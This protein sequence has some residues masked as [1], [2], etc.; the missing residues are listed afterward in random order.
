MPSIQILFSDLEAGFIRGLK[1]CHTLSQNWH[2]RV[3]LSKLTRALDHLSE[4][5]MEIYQEKVREYGK[6]E[7]ETF[8]VFPHLVEKERLP[9]WLSFIGEWRKK[10]LEYTFDTPREDGRL[11]VKLSKQ[12]LCAIPRELMEAMVDYVE[13]A[14]D[15]EQTKEQDILTQLD[16]LKKEV[17]A[18][19]KKKEG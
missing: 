3:K 2:D 16:K 19:T 13:F 8:G 7:G 4:S 18:L 15:T 1:V 14:E 5:D 11:E 12:A 6:N 17:E 9:E 10:S